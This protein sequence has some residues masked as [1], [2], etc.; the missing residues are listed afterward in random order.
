MSAFTRA[1]SPIL[2]SDAIPAIAESAVK[3]TIL[4]QRL[5]ESMDN[6]GKVIAIFNRV[7][8]NPDATEETTLPTMP[9]AAA[10]GG[11]A[12][13]GESERYEYTEDD[14]AEKERALQLKM[15]GFP[16]DGQE[17]LP[18]NMKGASV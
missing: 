17:P 15:I 10:P 12:R 9:T 18:K 14:A 5:T 6:V 2:K 1:F 16:I 3:L 7:T 13:K 8:F 11:F 4:M